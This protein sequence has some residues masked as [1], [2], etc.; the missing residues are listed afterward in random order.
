MRHFFT[1]KKIA[2]ILV[3]AGAILLLTSGTLAEK[4]EDSDW[5][6]DF[7]KAQEQ[8]E[9]KNRPIL[10]NFSGSD[11]CGWCIRLDKEVFSKKEFQQFA[12]EEL[13][14]L[15]VDFPRNKEQSSE[16]KQ[17]NQELAQKYGAKGF[18]TIL[19]LDAD[20]KELA[21]TGYKRGGADN[22]IDHLKELLEKNVEPEKSD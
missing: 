2:G 10:V 6:T 9:K 12:K 18:P 16:T 14:L 11:W 20:G 15:M 1:A 21:R 13:I 4:E 17:Q 22:Y 19:L 5:L 7:E 3:V 8:A